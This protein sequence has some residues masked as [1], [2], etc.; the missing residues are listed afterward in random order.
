MNKYGTEITEHDEDVLNAITEVM[1]GDKVKSS[2]LKERFKNELVD[3]YK[4]EL[5]DMYKNK[6]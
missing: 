2:S 1:L 3:M 6:E 5:V 4:N